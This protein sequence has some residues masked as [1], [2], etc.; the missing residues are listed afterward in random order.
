MFSKPPPVPA[1][2]ARRLEALHRYDIL[3]TPPEPAFDD[4]AR[5][6][7]HICGTSTALVSFVDEHRQWFKASVG[8]DVRET[9]R[10]LAFCA[11]AVAEPSRPLVVTDTLADERFA[12]H[13]LVLDG[14]RIRFYAGAQL[15]T[16]DGL[17]LGTLCAIDQE[18]RELTAAQLSA[19]QALARQVVDQL[20]LRRI[21][22]RLHGVLDELEEARRQSE[23]ARQ[24]ALHLAKARSEFLAMMSHEIRTPLNGVLGMLSLIDPGVVDQDVREQLETA[25]DSAEVVLRLVN[26]LLDLAKAD[27]GRVVLNDEPFDLHAL[28]RDVR[29]MFCGR[30][31]VKGLELETVIRQPVPRG[32]RGDAS[33]LIQVLGNLLGNAVKFTEK[34]RVRLTV[35]AVESDRIRFSVADTGIG[36]PPERQAHV[37]EPFVQADA[38]TTRRFGGT[39]LGL[40]ICRRLVEAMHGSVALESRPGHGSTFHVVVP[41]PAVALADSAAADAGVLSEQLAGMRILVAED[42]IV[43]Q[44][45]AERMLRKLGCD[46]AVVTNGQDALAR[47]G[48]GFDA[49]LMDCRMPVMDGYEAAERIVATVPGA[50]P[51][52]ALTASALEDDHARCVASGM[53]A[54][55]AKPVRLET[56]AQALGAHAVKRPDAAAGNTHPAVLLGA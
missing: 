29:Q 21:I 39:G 33:R 26:D 51:I 55:L 54:C 32:V 6:V 12:D 45:V 41:L 9:P 7:A 28:V 13:P 15:M 23:E 31:G 48:D 43:N 44:R 40:A 35:E 53:R 46:V 24:E 5:V 50:P 20:E 14:P 3:D 27:A 16:S 25:K 11:H 36:I 8:F 17:A 22:E 18:P 34:G 42:N 30:A 47:A 52:L 10:D 38:S 37:F 1:N 2:E 4:L 49:I 19:L 56:L